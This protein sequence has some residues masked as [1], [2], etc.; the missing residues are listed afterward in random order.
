LPANE[1]PNDKRPAKTCHPLAQIPF[2]R[3]LVKP[4]ILTNQ[5]EVALERHYFALPV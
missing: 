1:L 4:M 5:T 2:E 3:S